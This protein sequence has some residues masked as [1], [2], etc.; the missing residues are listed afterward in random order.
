MDKKKLKGLPKDVK[1]ST[2]GKMAVL[3]YEKLCCLFSSGRLG[4]SLDE[5]ADRNSN[6][7][8]ELGSVNIHESGVRTLNSFYLHPPAFALIFLKRDNCH[9]GSVGIDKVGLRTYLDEIVSLS[10]FVSRNY[11][12]GHFQAFMNEAFV[13]E[14]KTYKIVK[15]IS[16]ASFCRVEDVW[17][18]ISYEDFLND[19]KGIPLSEATKMSQEAYDVPDF[20]EFYKNSL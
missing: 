9:F 7:D 11:S 12:S 14:I 8:L 18:C 16:Q 10:G 15:S 2:E 20:R 13:N 19:I 3:E 6:L 5:I 17:G 4:I 1:F